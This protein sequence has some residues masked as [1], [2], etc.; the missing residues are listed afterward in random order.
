MRTLIT[1][2]LFSV[3]AP[4]FADIDAAGAYDVKFEEVGHNCDPPPVALTRSKL[5]VATYPRK[6]S[7]TVNID[8]IPEMIGVPEHGGK[9]K[10]T[11]VKIL[12]TTVQGLDARYSVA[13][14]VDDG[15]VVQLV[16]TAEYQRHDNHKPYCTQS[17]NLT[18]LRPIRN[19]AHAL[20]SRL[21][22][23]CNPRRDV[24]ARPVA[25]PRPAR[26]AGGTDVAKRAT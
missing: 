7:L 21:R 3:S 23:S 18:G 15:G 1:L 11:T 12:P 10:A 20:P 19:S 26:L 6:N 14:K 8:T 13:G 2:L 9:I 17:W 16:L 25:S 5:V 24:F 4:A 22:R